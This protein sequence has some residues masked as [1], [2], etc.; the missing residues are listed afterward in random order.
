MKKQKLMLL[1]VTAI[2][3][4]MAGTASAAMSLAYRLAFARQPSMGIPYSISYMAQLHSQMKLKALNK[5][6]MARRGTPPTFDITEVT[7]QAPYGDSLDFLDW[8]IQLTQTDGTSNYDFTANQWNLNTFDY[9]WN[10][11]A[12]TPGTYNVSIYCY[13]ERSG[14]YYDIVGFGDDS[15]GN[16]VTFADGETDYQYERQPWNFTGVV[17]EGGGLYLE[18]SGND[19]YH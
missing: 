13:D 5:L 17:A 1:A 10:F 9:T 3:V 6:K 15:N 4:L 14:W 2:C 8:E 18:L 11:G 16:D 19:G 7:I 12:I